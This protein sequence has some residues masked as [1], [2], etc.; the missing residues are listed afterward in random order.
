MRDS[1]A[2]H[3]IL[4]GSLTFAGSLCHL[5]RYYL[6]SNEHRGFDFYYVAGGKLRIGDVKCNVNRK[7]DF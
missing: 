2:R 1:R 5:Y 6:G 7:V 4:Y 3:F